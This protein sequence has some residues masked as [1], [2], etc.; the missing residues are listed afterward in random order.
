MS[1]DKILKAAKA[2]VKGNSQSPKRA[3]WSLSASSFTL[4]EGDQEICIH[5]EGDYAEKIGADQ[6]GI[7]GLEL[8]LLG[9]C[10]GVL[11]RTKPA[12]ETEP[13]TGLDKCGHLSPEDW[14]RVEWVA[15]ATDQKSTRY[16]LGGVCFDGRQVVGTDGRRLHVADLGLPFARSNNSIV[17]GR[18]VGAVA[19]L[20]KVF[21]VKEFF[22]KFSD[23][24]VEIYCEFFH[25]KSRLVEGSYP[26]W[27]SV[28]P[29]DS[30]EFSRALLGKDLIG[31]CKK[32]E[33]IAALKNK[34]EKNDDLLVIPKIAVGDFDSLHWQRVDCRFLREAL[35]GLLTESLNVVARVPDCVKLPVVLDG[36]DL[37]AVIMPLGKLC[38]GPLDES[39]RTY[40]EVLASSSAGA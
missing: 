20:L 13:Q 30:S 15:L 29:A 36:G 16:Q 32:E 2:V 25:F 27:E 9:E 12:W 1:S 26:K 18:T 37:R 14:K 5:I 21:G 3:R 39:K 8:A 17:S 35:E 11:V 34:G 4:S 6:Q 38:G 19:S 22:L 24:Q 10:S 31:V 7:D 23:F 40:N 28:C 33:K